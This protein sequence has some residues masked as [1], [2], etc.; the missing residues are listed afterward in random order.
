MAN[1]LA[2][3]SVCDALRTFLQRAYDTAVAPP[4]PGASFGVISAASINTA[5][6]SG[7]DLVTVF[8]Y[9]VT[10]NEHQRN[11]RHEPYRERAPLT[12]D[13]H[14]MLTAWSTTPRTEHALLTWTMRE[15]YQRPVLDLSLLSAEAGW[16]PGDAVQIVPA[17]L[18]NEDLMRLW[19][20]LTPPYHLSITYVA[21]MLRIDA[22][23]LPTY[24]PVV[25]RRIAIEEVRRA[26]APN[27]AEEPSP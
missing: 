27:A 11:L 17:E 20:A 3:F 12:L 4:V 9:R 7:Q 5:A 16:E 24:G 21:R 8:L 13:L 26:D 1:T 22:D 18:S 19:E 15:L 14:L 23:P 2:T 25:A 6:P 10:V